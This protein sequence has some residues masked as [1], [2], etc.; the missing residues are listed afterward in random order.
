MSQFRKAVRGPEGKPVFAGIVPRHHSAME[1]NMIGSKTAEPDARHYELLLHLLSQSYVDLVPDQR[2]IWDR[3]MI[4]GKISVLATAVL[5]GRRYLPELSREINTFADRSK[6]VTLL[7]GLKYRLMKSAITD[8][9]HGF[10]HGRS[11]TRKT[12]MDWIATL[13]ALQAQLL[14]EKPLVL[15]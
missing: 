8:L 7:I 14:M 3:K 13:S 6:L 11:A 9:N 10:Q 5:N 15:H 2:S 12:L 1:D 4:F